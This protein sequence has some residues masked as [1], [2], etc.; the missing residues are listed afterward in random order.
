MGV[1]LKLFVLLVSLTLAL[2]PSDVWGRGKVINLHEDNWEQML[3]DEWMVEFYAPWCPACRALESVWT[4][5][6]SWSDDLGIKVA[7]VDVTTSPGLSGRFIVTAL[8][9]IY[10]VLN[11]EFRQYHGTRDKD[12]FM[13][14]IEQKKWETLEPIPSW[15]S[16]ASFHM[17]ATAYFFKLSQLLRAVHNRLMEDY[18]L[19]TWGSYLIFAVATIVLGALLG[20]I[21]VCVIDYLYPCKPSGHHTR[22]VG[23]VNKEVDLLDRGDVDDLVDED[24]SSSQDERYSRSQSSSGAEEEEEEDEEQ[25]QEKEAG[26]APSSPGNAGKARQR[27][28]RKAD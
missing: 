7:K 1:S 5:F 24:C 3:T 15:K 13:T 21:M 6:S 10:H 27:R 12:S 25:E 22:T 26:S 17:G 20:L 19:P 2:Y 11:G 16:P 23:D 18:G 28:A 9:T 4:E 14:F 8:P